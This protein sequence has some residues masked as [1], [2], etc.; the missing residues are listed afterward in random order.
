MTV[1]TRLSFPRYRRGFSERNLEAHRL[2]HSLLKRLEVASRCPDLELCVAATVELNDD[3]FASVVDFEPGNR[4]GMAAV[5]TFRHAE[6]RSEGA[7]GPAQRRRQLRVLRM[8]AFRRTATVISRDEGH[9]FDLIGMKAAQVA[10]LDQ[11]VGVLVMSGEA[12]MPTDVVHQRRVFQPLALAFR[13][14]MDAAC[15]IEKREREA[16][17][18]IGVIGVIAAALRQFQGA[19]APYVRNAVDLR[20]L[21]AIAPDV[22]EHEPFAERQIAEGQ[23]LS[24]EAAKNRVEQHRAGDHQVRAPRVEPWNREST[25]QVEVGDLLPEPADLLGGDMKIA[26]LRWRSASGSSGRNSA[27]AQDGPRR[28]D[29]TVETCREDLFT[30]AVDFAKD[31][32]DDLPLVSVGER[33]AAHEPL[34]QTNRANLETSSK[35]QGRRGAERDFDAAAADVDDNGAS[36]A[37]VDAIDRSLMNEARLFGS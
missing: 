23:F 19:P 8:R 4:L 3:V 1:V 29:D 27:D 31:V 22:I 20:D 34:R 16:H 25:F 9:H 12:D 32:L 2:A 15:L 10:V 18:L 5:E 37:Y 36:A 17:H 6:Y 11:V 7:H 13:Q 35:L 28:P 24:A 30:V 21:A 26:Q 14:S 33:I